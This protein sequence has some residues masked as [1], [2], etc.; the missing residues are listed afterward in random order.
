MITAKE[1]HQQEG[2]FTETVVP[3]LFAKM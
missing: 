2:L 3:C 1:N